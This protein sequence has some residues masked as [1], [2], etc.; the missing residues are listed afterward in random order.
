M[1]GFR[2]HSG[3]T[4]TEA[5]PPPLTRRLFAHLPRADQR[6]WA[7]V[8][9]RGLLSTPGKK[10][11]RRMAASVTH[12]P[13]AS[14]SLQQFINVSPWEWEPVR[15]EL[16]QWVEE[17][18]AVRAWTL[19]PVVVPK[20][21]RMS[22]GVHRRFVPALGRTVNCQLAVGAFL[23]SELG[24]VPVDWQLYL[25]RKWTEDVE[26]R[27]RARIPDGMA[28]VSVTALCLSLLDRLPRA[29]DHPLPVVVDAEGQINAEALIAGIEDRGHDWI[30]AVPGTLRVVPSLAPDQHLRLRRTAGP[31]SGGDTVQV[32][33]RRYTAPDAALHAAMAP[34]GAVRLSVLRTIVQL[35][36][37]SRDCLLVGE[38][39]SQSSRPDR[40]WLSN[41]SRTRQAQARA[42]IAAHAAARAETEEAGLGLRDFGGRSYPGWHR[43][44]TLV[45]AACAHRSIDRGLYLPAA[46]GLRAPTAVRAAA[47]DLD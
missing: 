21:G 24:E 40:I 7:S 36:G 45:S 33:L 27:A 4:G 43:H 3:S 10:S 13:T 32:L 47:A 15:A 8:Y 19:S 44:A 12:S 34:P 11:V 14:Q 42:L 20:R 39:S 6:R 16:A 22:V 18:A 17:H 46:G 9:L 41:L 30:V 25:P 37:R 1:N 38:W 5:G 26:L 35:T 29:G 28:H 2:D 31:E 23:S